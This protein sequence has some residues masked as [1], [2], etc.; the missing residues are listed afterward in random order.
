MT[1]DQRFAFGTN[2]LDFSSR[3]LAAEGRIEQAAASLVEFIGKEDL[4][5][6]SFL[7]IG[8]G[9]G[10]FSLAA[11]QLGARVFSFDYDKES[12][13]CTRELKQRYAGD[14]DNQWRV[15]LGSILNAE[16]ISE[17]GQY[18]IVY[19]WGVLHH[20]GDLWAAFDRSLGLV[21]PR[22]CAYV[23]IY[24]HQP[25]L[26]RV[27]AVIKKIYG[28]L[29]S[30]LRPAYVL[31]YVMTEWSV[32]VVV[33]ILRMRNP[34]RRF[35]RVRRGMDWWHDAVDWVGGWPFETATHREVVARGRR[36]GF[37]VTRFRAADGHGCNE[38]LLEHR[39][40]I[41]GTKDSQSEPNRK[42]QMPCGASGANMT[43]AD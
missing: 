22:G 2:W 4:T 19:S 5:G 34:A 12:V 30:A 27:F 39:P 15:E 1:T 33:D 29:P 18:D 25:I 10:L 6:L 8:S 13:I 32:A 23:A 7:D 41:F 11:W 43:S 36:M 20:T 42:Q 37:A 24:N 17:V 40:E 28:V 16:Y 31:I 26:S 35:R 38:Y 3:D 14:E 21:A 9:S